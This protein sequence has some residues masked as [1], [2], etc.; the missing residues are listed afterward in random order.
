MYSPLIEGM[1][2]WWEHD[3]ELSV[4]NVCFL[5]KGPQDAQRL[6]RSPTPVSSALWTEAECHS[7]VSWLQG[8]QSPSV[9]VS[10]RAAEVIL[11]KEIKGSPAVPAESSLKGRFITC[12][13]VKTAHD[14]LPFTTWE[15][16]N[17]CWL[18]SST[19]KKKKKMLERDFWVWSIQ[20]VSYFMN[21]Q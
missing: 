12:C 2:Q 3:S 6:P 19:L 21:P 4:Q 10:R 11:L 13:T 1:P 7:P 9:T 15:L 14:C 18:K 17:G 8:W 5:R 16:A 20:I